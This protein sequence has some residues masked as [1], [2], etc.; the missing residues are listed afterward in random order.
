MPLE[1]TAAFRKVPDGYVAFVEELP[2]ANTQGTTLDEARSNLREAVELTLEA[3]RALAEVLFGE[4]SGDSR[5]AQA[6]RVK[7]LDLIRHLEQHGCTLFREGGNH[8]VFI[9]RATRKS[10]TVP[11]PSRN[12]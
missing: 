12:R 5:A 4:C 10:S 11:R 8:S 1:F 2:G 7:R 6:H 3:N 9:D